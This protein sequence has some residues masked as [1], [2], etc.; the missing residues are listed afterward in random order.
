ME[1]WGYSHYDSLIIAA[2]LQADCEILY[3][4]DL[5]HRQ[6]IRDLT[7]IDPFRG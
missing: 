2:A 5:H 3:S 1:R 6:K 7:I 4:E